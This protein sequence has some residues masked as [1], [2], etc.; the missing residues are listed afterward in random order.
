MEAGIVRY[1]GNSSWVYRAVSVRR[2]SAKENHGNHHVYVDALDTDGR[3]VPGLKIGFTWVGRKDDEPAP[4]AA[5]DKQ[6]GEAMGNLPIFW[7]QVVDVWL[8]GQASDKVTGLHTVYPSDGEGNGSGH[9]SFKVV[10]QLEQQGVTPA[11]EPA[12]PNNSSKDAEQDARL[13]KIEAYLWG[14]SNG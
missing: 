3:R 14:G 12:S 13:A 8:E 6:P 2:L 10:F 7:G 4:P 11:P 9:H 1:Q 5:M